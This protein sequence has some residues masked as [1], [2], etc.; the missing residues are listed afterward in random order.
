MSY[1]AKKL[2]AQVMHE[3]SL[4]DMQWKKKIWSK[5]MEALEILALMPDILACPM[6]AISGT[7]IIENLSNSLSHRVGALKWDGVKT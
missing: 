3:M 1:F 2:V 4:L 7:R 5:L 6:Q